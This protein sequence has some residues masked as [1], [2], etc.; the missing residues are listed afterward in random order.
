MYDG[1]TCH[2]IAYEDYLYGTAYGVKSIKNTLRDTNR[3]HNAIRNSLLKS[4]SKNKA[5]ISFAMEELRAR[6]EMDILGDYIHKEQVNDIVKRYHAIQNSQQYKDIINLFKNLANKYK[7]V[8]VSAPNEYR[9]KRAQRNILASRF[10]NELALAGNTVYDISLPLNPS[11]WSGENEFKTIVYEIFLRGNQAL[12]GRLRGY[13]TSRGKEIKIRK[14]IGHIY[15]RQ[16]K[17][18]EITAQENK[19]NTRERFYNDINT[20]VNNK[21]QETREKKYKEI[22][23]HDT[24]TLTHTGY[25]FQPNNKQKKLYLK[26]IKQQIHAAVQLKLHPSYI[27]EKQDL[28]YYIINGKKKQHKV[29][30][31]DKQL[32][33]DEIHAK[34]IQ[35]NSSPE[36]MEYYKNLVLKPS[37]AQ[38]M[39]HNVYRKMSNNYKMLF[40]AQDLTLEHPALKDLVEHLKTYPDFNPEMLSRIPLNL[41]DYFMLE[42]GLHFGILPEKNTTYV[43]KLQGNTESSLLEFYESSFYKSNSTDIHRIAMKIRMGNYDLLGYHS[44][45]RNRAMEK[46]KAAK[47]PPKQYAYY[48]PVTC[49]RF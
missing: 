7:Y 3:S 40:G 43:L 47:K 6:G 9:F 32:S 16:N 5:S 37:T 30:A 29:T 44:N 4:K 14:I 21:R 13:A 31:A 33:M 49:S 25:I 38:S 39:L 45:L 34:I 36:L 46:A 15:E 22:L 10:I 2:R 20:F 35:G 41:H 27:R 17:H 1:Q 24:S 23:E 26:P 8:F 28:L 18:R 11:D 42:V 48:D 12:Q 19:L